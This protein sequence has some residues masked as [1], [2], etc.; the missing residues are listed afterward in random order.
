MLSDYR[1][2]KHDVYFPDY[3]VY[4]LEATGTSFNNDMI[5]EISAVRVRNHEVVAEY[6][7]FVNPERSILNYVVSVH[8]IT[9]DMVRDEPTIREILP[10]FLYFI[11]NDVLVGHNIHNFDNRFYIGFASNISGKFLTMTM[12]TRGKYSRI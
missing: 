7:R 12:W 5:V 2:K 3:V 10:E 8:G 11:G 4:D 9:D 1:G 6:S